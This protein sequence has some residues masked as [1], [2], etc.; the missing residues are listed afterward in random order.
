VRHSRALALAAAL[1]V[2]PALLHAQ[3]PPDDFIVTLERDGTSCGG[4]CPSYSVTI[5]SRGE[6]V[7]RGTSF[8]RVEGQAS[9]GI[10]VSQVGALLSTI[11]RIGFFD[12]RDS[13][14]F[15]RTA[16]GREVIQTHQ[17]R[18]FVSVT[19]HGRTK[20]IEDY[21]G[22]PEA[23]RDLERQ[24]ES[25]ART[26]RWVRIDVATLRQMAEDGR[27]PSAAA[28]QRLLRAALHADEVDVVEQ[29]LAMGADPNTSP[30]DDHEGPTRPLLL[31]RSAAAA[32]ALIDAGAD[33]SAADEYGQTA[34][35]MAASLQPQIAEVLL[36]AG[37][38]VDGPVDRDG[39]TA[40]MRAAAAGNLGVVRLLVSAGAD[41]GYPGPNGTALDCARQAKEFER[42]L[43]LRL[44]GVT[45]APFVPDFDGVIAAL[46]RALTLRQR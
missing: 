7:Y 44:E 36:N 16:D 30:G 2:I 26:Q 33:A 25:T 3:A 21:F 15:F 34:M 10:P 19:S 17:W 22:A 20:R 40:L 1:T 41:P 35:K 12:L 8:V 24:I 5:N 27:A 39:S 14:I 11:D 4:P 29:L 13:Y 38:P 23:L 45:T 6:I 37:A 18:T 31:V 32:R 43:S 46:E 28:R 9:D 42:S